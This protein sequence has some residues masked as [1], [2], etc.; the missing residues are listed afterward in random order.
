M[1]ILLTNDDGIYAPGLRVLWQSLCQEHQVFVVA[2]DVERSAIGHAIT[3]HSPIQVKKIRDNGRFFGY[4]LSGTPADC[5]KIAL[6]DLLEVK[7]DVVI[8]GINPGANLGVSL[9]YSGTVSAA[10]EAAICGVPALAVSLDMRDNPDFTFSAEFTRKVVGRLPS[11]A[12]AE[13]VSLNINIPALPRDQI[14]GVTWTRQCLASLDEKV[15]RRED[16]DGNTYFWMASRRASNSH[17]D[18]DITLLAKNMITITP[19]KHD[20]THHEELIR[21]RDFQ[22]E[23]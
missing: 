21:L 2:P 12:L 20:L 9:Y 7:P 6:T 11:L 16:P 3:I 18:S 8:S 17:P 19:V 1:N 14:Q 15:I 4:A 22:F 23:I 10:R 13:H 5:V